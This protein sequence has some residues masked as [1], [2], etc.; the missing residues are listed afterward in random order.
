MSDDKIEVHPSITEKWFEFRHQ[1]PFQATS[2]EYSAVNALWLAEC[3]RLIYCQEWATIETAMKNAGFNEF[4]E[5]ENA[6]TEAFV[7]FNNVSMIICFRGTEVT[8]SK[9]IKTD[10]KALH[11]ETPEGWK[12]FMKH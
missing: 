4:K 8:S 2:L 10:I 1:Y 12:D 6:D 7:A 5:F 9:D 11:Y 3:S